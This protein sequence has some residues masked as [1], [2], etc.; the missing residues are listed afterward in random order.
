MPR[1]SRIDAPGAPHHIICRGID[2]QAIFHDDVDRKNFLNRFGRILTEAD[3]ACYAW[4]L[5]PNHFHL[6]LRTGSVPISTVLR[7]LLT[8]HAVFFNRR[9]HR[10]GHLFQNRYKSILCQEDAYLLEL[11]RYIHLNPLRAK[12][13]ENYTSLGSYA[14]CGHGMILGHQPM[15]WQDTDYILRQFGEKKAPARRK[16]R[17]FVKKGIERAG[18]PDLVGG[19]LIR[20]QGGWAAVKSLRR[21]GAFQKG[22]ERILGDGHFVEEVLTKANEQFEQRHRLA[23][24]GFNLD[25]IAQRVG[26][27]FGISPDEV[28]ES[29]KGQR[30][31][32]ARSLLCYWATV[33]LGMSQTRLAQML[34]L[35]QPAVS[36]AVNRGR[37]LARIHQYRLPEKG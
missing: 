14:Y 6:L 7:R 31:V 4:A 2:R 5:I 13:V 34:N 22:D 19:G 10:F 3:T 28:M 36:Q 12:L 18:R 1:K 37:D 23:A 27:L 35:T 15:V 32:R 24:A 9:H 11:V 26:Q 17:E 25:T 16:Y 21:T 29:G 30:R 20:S 33:Q 8:G